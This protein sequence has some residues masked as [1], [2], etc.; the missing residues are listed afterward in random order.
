M[1]ILS[2][3]SLFPSSVNARHGVF[4]KHR[5]LK[6][7][8]YYDY[9]ISLIAPV[10][11][12]PFLPKKVNPYTKENM[13]EKVENI[14]GISV[15]H[16][17]Y[18][19]MP[20]VGMYFQPWF[21]YRSALKVIKQKPELLNDVKII[22]AHYAYPDGVAA[23]MLA[24]KLSLPSAITIRGSDINKLS[25][26]LLPRLWLKWAISKC[27]WLIPVSK[28]LFDKVAILHPE[29]TTKMTVV[30]NGV[31]TNIFNENA[32]SQE[33]K[34]N[35]NGQ[36]LILSVGNLIP[37]KGH[38]LVINAVKADET[39]QLMIIGSGPM[40]AELQ[41]QI[42]KNNLGHRVNIVGNIPQT[43]LAGIYA[44]ADLLILASESEGC[45]NVLLEAQACGTP[46][47]STDVGAARDLMIEGQTGLI[48]QR[49]STS[50]YNTIQE[51]FRAKLTIIIKEFK[52][53]HSWQPK[54]EQIDRLFQLI[55]N[56]KD[57]R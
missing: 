5:L 46:V 38:N 29:S 40:E 6:I 33:Y 3:T 34:I 11:A 44:Q 53:A 37:L 57:G 17:R 30:A 16:P 21:M 26:Y 23:V 49:T 43:D 20:L 36:K 14:E 12:A 4:V 25:E 22:D 54:V 31:D 47:I 39:L 15:Y 41:Q 42:K 1:K 52:A 8:E 13:V 48:M 35:K 10:P 9:K 27:D 50:I 7:M 45:P 28:S 19:H 2:F 51:A 18:F 55:G 24:K 56:K 32:V